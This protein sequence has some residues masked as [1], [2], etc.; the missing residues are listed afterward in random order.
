MTRGSPRPTVAW[1]LIRVATACILFAAPLGFSWGVYVLLRGIAS[2]V[3][4]YSALI[5]SSVRREGWAWTFG[6]LALL[7]NPIFPVHL[8]RGLWAIVDF[9]TAGILLWSV[10]SLRPTKVANGD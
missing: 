4:A 5:A 7:F 8:G 1:A 3:L 2:P 9:V 10:F 6:V